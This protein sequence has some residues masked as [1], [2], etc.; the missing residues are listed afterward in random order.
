MVNHLWK[1]ELRFIRSLQ[2]LQAVKAQDCPREPPTMA[3]PMASKIAD[4]DLEDYVLM[5][6]FLEKEKPLPE[7]AAILGRN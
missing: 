2:I 7:M 4:T 6:M 1:S 5:V 3:P